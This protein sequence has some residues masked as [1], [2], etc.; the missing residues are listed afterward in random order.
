[1]LDFAAKVVG[2]A[3]LSKVE[4][5]PTMSATAMTV[6]MMPGHRCSIIPFL[7]FRTILFHCRAITATV[8][9]MPVSCSGIKIFLD[10]VAFFCHISSLD[11]SILIGCGECAFLILPRRG[12]IWN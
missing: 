6:S 2:S 7:N 10:F 8:G 5:F 12:M 9:I 11:C 3:G 4:E 1:M